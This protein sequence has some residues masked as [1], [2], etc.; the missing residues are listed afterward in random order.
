M[1]NRRTDRLERLA[2]QVEVFE[3]LL[4]VLPHPEAV[5]DDARAWVEQV[6]QTLVRIPA[7]AEAAVRGWLEGAARFQSTLA[8]RPAS[9]AGSLHDSYPTTVPEAGR[10]RIALDWT[11]EALVIGW[12]GALDSDALLVVVD[13]AGTPVVVARLDTTSE[14]GTFSA[15]GALL[16]FSPTGRAWSIFVVPTPA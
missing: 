15:P 9:A 14:Q 13:D 11:A 2:W 12:E 4:A 6:R 5:G 7:E 16:G 1:T 10:L 8:G 3:T